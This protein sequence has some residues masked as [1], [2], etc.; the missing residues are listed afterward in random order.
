M[1]TILSVLL[2]IFLSNTINAQILSSTNTVK[3]SVNDAQL[4][5]KAYLTPF[6]RGVSSAGSNGFISFSNS[7]NKIS[8]NF[9]INFVGAITPRDERTYDV[10][11]L[12]L[13]E[14]KASDPN[15]SIAQTFSGD[16]S[17]IQLETIE[18]YQALDNDGNLWGQP[19]LVDKPLATFDSPS[20]TGIAFVALPYINGGIYAFGTHANFRILPKL[21]IANNQADVLSIGG[22]IQHNLKQFIKPLQDFPV[23]FNVLVGFQKTYFNYYLDVKPDETRYEIK[24]QNNGPYDNQVLKI[25]TTSIPIQ[26]IISKN[27]KG[28]DIYSGIGYNITNSDVSLIGNYPIYKSDPSHTMQILV[29]DVKNPFAYS[30]TH[31]EFRF[32]IGLQYQIKIFKIFTNYT[33]AKY[34]AFNFGVGINY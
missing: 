9:S 12:G 21:H 24:L 25:N 10:N 7:K 14:I 17:T 1:K 34:S 28:F 31:N 16:E 29:E 19:T 6:V 33:F 18:T 15:N 27:Y 3:G 2:I 32:D 11:K 4:L 26:F 8:F 23:E 30:Q 22:D 5:T 13:Q 20:G